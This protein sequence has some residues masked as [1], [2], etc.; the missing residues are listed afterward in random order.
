MFYRSGVFGGEKKGGSFY[1]VHVSK[2]K[3]QSDEVGR[4][5]W[6]SLPGG[7]EE[8]T[9]RVSRELKIEPD[10][11][12]DF[13]RVMV[14]ADLIH[15]ASEEDKV[16]G[17][18]KTQG[19]EIGRR[20]GGRGGREEG[21]KGEKGGEEK[22][23]KV[24]E[25][26]EREKEREERVGPRYYSQKDSFQFSSA[27]VEASVAAAET[28]EGGNGWGRQQRKSQPKIA[29][30]ARVSAIVVTYNSEE[31]IRECLSALEGQDYEPLEIIVVD[32]ASGDRTR[33]IVGQEFPPARLL[34][35]KKNIYFPA[36]VNKGL[37]VAEGDFILILND[38]VVLEAG[39]VAKLV[40]RLEEESQA[41]AVSPMMK[42][43]H[44]RGFING[45]GNHLRDCG[46]GSDNFI[47]LVDCGQF[48]ELR[49]VPSACFGAVLVRREAIE[50]VGPLDEHYKSYYEDVDWSFRAWLNGWKMAA[51][52]EA[53]AY[54][55][56]GSHWQESPRKLRLVIRNRLRLV[57]K[58][59]SGNV[60][61]RFLKN[62][63]GEDLRN[64]LTLLR[65]KQWPQAAS[66]PTAYLSLLLSLPEIF[67]KRR[68]TLR[69]KKRHFIGAETGIRG[70]SARP[71][72]QKQKGEKAES[73]KPGSCRG[74]LGSKERG[75]R[76]R[77]GL[78]VEEV[79][80][81]NPSFYSGL[82]EENI[83]VLDTAMMRR[84]YQPCLKK[85][86]ESSGQ[87]D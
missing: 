77:R 25:G 61:F 87:M 54:H 38:D 64:F 12:R 51:E 80:K 19:G 79:L 56:F 1:F 36:A 13:M 30:P 82:N 32:N 4:A 65:R 55:K 9:D 35:L 58:L 29:E 42:F 18:I 85:L 6:E 72:I 10:L 62:Y 57:L 5:I 14:A 60:F 15:P 66:Y 34:A 2:A 11:V 49:E 41:A 48:R 22:E 33:E 44:L 23:G 83:P 39:C 50:A 74:W 40:K 67:K 84:Y 59:F 52:A 37:E 47:G 17:E 63:G 45:I 8:I 20:L 75:G 21:G 76:G 28:S 81:K 3:V 31:H 46:W 26:K 16:K 69:I 7:E 73:Y 86:K 24:I 70:E 78:T 71:E 43:Y 68:E 27:Q 53:V